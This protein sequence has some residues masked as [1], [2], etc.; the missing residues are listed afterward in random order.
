MSPCMQTAMKILMRVSVVWPKD[1]A[2]QTF[3]ACGIA[4]AQDAETS[5]VIL[6]YHFWNFKWFF[7]ESLSGKTISKLYFQTKS[8]KK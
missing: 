5:E 4:L 2:P 6:I 1:S 7:K 8:G 3:R